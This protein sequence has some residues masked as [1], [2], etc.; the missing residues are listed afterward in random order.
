[1]VRCAAPLT[2][3]AVP[4][5]KVYRGGALR[6]RLLRDGDLSAAVTRPSA[7]LPLPR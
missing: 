1:M 4:G 5:D 3:R 2:P 7:A 6:H